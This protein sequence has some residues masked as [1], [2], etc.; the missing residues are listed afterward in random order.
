MAES[1]RLQRWVAWKE[2]LDGAWRDPD[3]IRDFESRGTPISIEDNRKF[4]A[5]VSVIDSEPK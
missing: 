5:K 1:R 3:V 2:I 4:D